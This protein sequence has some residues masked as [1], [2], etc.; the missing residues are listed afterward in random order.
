MDIVYRLSDLEADG[1]YLLVT[2]VTASGVTNAMT[3]DIAAANGDFT[4]VVDCDALFGGEVDSS[5]TLSLSLLEMTDDTVPSDATGVTIGAKGDVLIIDVSGGPSAAAYPVQYL[6][7]VD[8]GWFNCDAYKTGK[9]VMRRVPAGT[10]IAKPRASGARTDSDTLTSQNDY[11]IG[12]F[13][14]TQKQYENVM[15]T[16]PSGQSQTSDT[17]P[18][19][20]ISWSAVRGQITNPASAISP[21]SDSMCFLSRLIA[22]TGLFSL[23][24]PTE[25]QWQIAATAGS[26]EAYGSF[27][28]TS[29]GV[30][31]A[32]FT[33][34]NGKNEG[35]GYPTG[36]K[37]VGLSYPNLWGIYDM[38]GNV[39]E[40]CRDNS[41]SA[42]YV[43]YPDIP[44]EGADPNSWSRV[45]YGGG[46]ADGEWTTAIGYMSSTDRSSASAGRGI[47]LA[48]TVRS[49]FTSPS[50]I[51]DATGMPIGIRADILV[52]D[53]S[54]GST[55]SAYP[56]ARYSNVDIGY[57]NCDLYKSDKIVLRKVPAG[58]YRICPGASESHCPDSSEVVTLTKDFY[59]GL[60]EV[61][62]RQYLNVVG[63]W[64]YNGEANQKQ[65]GDTR[66]LGYVSYGNARGSNKPTD[67]V[68][69]DASSESFC[70]RLVA[71]TGLA[72][73]LPTEAQWEVAARGGCG[74]ACGAGFMESRLAVENIAG[75]TLAYS[76]WY[77]DNN[78][79]AEYPAGQKPVGLL[80]P[81]LMGLY[82]MLGN[83]AEWCR[84]GFA[85]TY[86]Y[87]YGDTSNP[88][89]GT[90]Y[91]H[92]GG[93]YA[94]SYSGGSDGIVNMVGRGKF[95]S[96]TQWDKL[97]FRLSLTCE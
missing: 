2:A 28:R 52:V 97:G 21:K 91:V 81:N 75:L 35:S 55:T 65:L 41:S 26:K 33:W 93:N 3:N 92:R 36:V 38:R 18:V 30:T 62:Q 72:F 37:P 83:V 49:K 87:D 25:G 64:P 57:F 86:S 42:S 16:I 15:G 54:S 40:L 32:W 29:D 56:I 1:R 44:D 9:I 17:R 89:S 80:A 24:I 7:G 71:K 77:A 11:Y 43:A 6:N 59:I 66:P 88:G 51:S 63:K 39:A 90:H 50:P 46:Y 47:R 14:L 8:M 70:P 79:T 78:T 84:D 74:F 76:A 31:K 58:K 27:I 10:Y 67:T 19:G 61:T 13:E 34:N 60:F 73:D 68:L 48:Y 4:A 20:N 94:G 82:D 69:G 95:T 5:A 22:R 12:V 53:V 45:M 23:D 96:N 85:D